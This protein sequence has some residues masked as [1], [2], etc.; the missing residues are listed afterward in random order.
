MTRLFCDFPLVVG[1]NIDLPKETSR[2]IQVLRLTEGNEIVLFNGEGGEYSARIISL[3]RTKTN[4][5]ILSR[6]DR[7][8]ELPYDITLAQALPEAGKM[9][10]IIEKAVELGAAG[11]QPLA[12]QRS[13]VR[14]NADRAEKRLARWQTIV[15]AASEQCGRNTLMEISEPVA[16]NTFIDNSG[17]CLRVMFTPRA[18]ET[19]SGWARKQAP[20]AITIMIGPEGGFSPEEE[21]LAIQNGVIPLSMGSRILRTETAGMAAIS[22]I[23]AIWDNGN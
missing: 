1:T 15:T 21:E 19:L 13:V 8:V 4:V 12:A 18:T 17:G 23:N 14:L 11:I 9:D 3:D 10:W 20:Q 2:H 16:F 22:A 5:K 7:E 6:H